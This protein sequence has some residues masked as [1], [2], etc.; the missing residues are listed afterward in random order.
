MESNMNN[1]KIISNEIDYFE[2]IFLFIE[3]I[4]HMNSPSECQI[5]EIINL[6]KN[7]DEKIKKETSYYLKK[8]LSET[9]FKESS[10]IFRYILKTIYNYDYSNIYDSNIIN[11]AFDNLESSSLHFFNDDYIIELNLNKIL[12]NEEITIKSIGNFFDNYYTTYEFDKNK[13]KQLFESLINE[14]NKITKLNLILIPFPEYEEIFNNIYDEILKDETIYLTIPERL[15]LGIIA[16]NSIGCDFLTKDLI[17][18]FI[19][20]GGKKDWII[21]G[22]NGAPEEFKKISKINN[23]L[24][25]Q[26]WTLNQNFLNESGFSTKIE[27]FIQICIIL[28]SFGRLANIILSFKFIIQNPDEIINNINKINKQHL[29]KNKSDNLSKIYKELKNCDNSKERK[30]IQLQLKHVYN[31]EKHQNNNKNE[32]KINKNKIY[33]EFFND[34]CIQYE[35]FNYHSYEFKSN[36]IYDFETSIFYQLQDYWPNVMNLIKKDYKFICEMTS[37]CVGNGEKLKSVEYFR[38]AIITYVEKLF[39]FFDETFDYSKTNKLLIISLK[40]CIKNSVC[41]PYRINYDYVYS[42]DYNIPDLIHTILLSTAVKEKVQLSYLA[43][44]FNTVRD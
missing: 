1:I 14:N 27:K 2:E 32:I 26:P 44:L 8:A 38:R 28:I 11:S 31:K 20:N 10:L 4:I 41:Y 29:I 35:D 33:S 34:F 22:L 6:I 36:Y 12:N 13:S 9:I 18:N 15:Y 37:Y 21:K 24:M 5:T 25:N 42:K 3:D 43:L 23:I 16:S 39:G 7:K 19:I 30:A 17:Q 40:D